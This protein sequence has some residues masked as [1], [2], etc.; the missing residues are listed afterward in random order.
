MVLQRCT[1]CECGIEMAGVLLGNAEA[2]IPRH[3]M[4]FETSPLDY[5][6]NFGWDALS[7]LFNRRS[8]ALKYDL[9]HISSPDVTR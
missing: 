7:R 1:S 9:L 5:S 3:V 6:V 8:F 2:H 4:Y